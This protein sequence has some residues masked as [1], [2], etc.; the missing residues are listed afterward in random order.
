MARRQAVLMYAET[1]SIDWPACEVEGCR[2]RQVDD[3]WHCLAHTSPQGRMAVF[4]RLAA[5]EAVDA[6]TGVQFTEELKHRFGWDR[7]R[8]DGIHGARIWCGHGMFAHNLVKVGGLLEAKHHKAARASKASAQAVTTTLVHRRELGRR[9]DDPVRPGLGD[10]SRHGRAAGGCSA[11]S[12]R[13]SSRRSPRGTPLETMRC[14][15]R[16][17]ATARQTVTALIVS[18]LGACAIAV[19]VGI[20]LGLGAVEPPWR[21]ATCRR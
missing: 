3:E 12:T 10:H 7:T 5:G 14:C 4:D 9:R 16:V 18:R 20:P 21:A 15:V 11:R 1:A 6:A 2:G 8:L 13:S 19:V 17:G